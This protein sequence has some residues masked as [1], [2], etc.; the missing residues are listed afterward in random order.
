[1]TKVYYTRKY[2]FD[3]DEIEVIDEQPGSTQKLPEFA[4][5][6]NTDDSQTAIDELSNELGIKTQKQ[7]EPFLKPLFEVI[8]NAD[9][10][11]TMITKIA[12]L[13][14]KLNGEKITSV[15]EKA[16]FL[17]ETLGQINANE[18]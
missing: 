6:E 18:N 13:Y 7:I 10:Y 12:E 5:P 1:L 17:S 14:P 4:A 16:M 2:D 9:S 8:N 3:E 15:L 11:E